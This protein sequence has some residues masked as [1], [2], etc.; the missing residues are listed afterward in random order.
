MGRDL[1]SVVKFGSAISFL[2]RWWLSTVLL[3]FMS[4]VLLR[5]LPGGPFDVEGR[6]HPLVREKLEETWGLKQDL[7]NQFWLY[8]Q[9]VFHLELGYSLQNPG[10]SVADLILARFSY[11]W[12]LNLAACFIVV[13]L[14]ATFAILAF[15]SEA[16]KKFVFWFQRLVFSIPILFL[17]PLS[18]FIFSFWLEWVPFAFLE[19]PLSYVLPLF[20]LC[21]RPVAILSQIQIR[22]QEEVSKQNYIL[23][24]RSKGL[25][26]RRLYFVHILKNTLPM[27]TA[28]LPD[29]FVGLISGSFLV[30]MLFSIPGVGLLFVE[31]L[32]ERDYP[33]IVG[34][35]LV[36][37][38]LFIFLSQLVEYLNA[39][40]DPRHRVEIS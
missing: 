22:H 2:L 20:V 3:I 14:G 10:Q 19:S 1:V 35:T 31:S 12:R 30:E 5:L 26:H 4:F 34:I 17:A 37:G 21:V 11:S 15:Y 23:V 32:G 28:Y 9:S 40:V 16:A 33:L 18:M 38:M 27:S 36:F 39:I 29:I 6:M 25:S 8:T 24:A 7:F 13:F